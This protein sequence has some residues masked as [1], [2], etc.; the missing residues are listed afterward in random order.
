MTQPEKA[1]YM[2]R[3]Q[4]L[5]KLFI[6]SWKIYFFTWEKN[7]MAIEFASYLCLESWRKVKTRASPV[8]P[9]V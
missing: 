3:G 6:V 1:R 8:F 7:N 9:F 5:G 2:Q 4:E